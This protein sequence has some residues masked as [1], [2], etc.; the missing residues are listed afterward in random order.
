L[1]HACNLPEAEAQGKKMCGIAGF[2][3]SELS[4]QQASDSLQLMLKQLSRRGPDGHGTETRVVAPWTVSLGHRRLSIIDVEGGVQPMR[5][6][7]GD[8]FITFNGEI[9]N[10]QEIALELQKKGVCLRTRSDTEV[11]LESLATSDE[12]E[13]VLNALNGMFAFAFWDEKQQ[14]LLMARDRTG[15]KPL[16]YAQL[17]DGG[18][19]F[20]S[21][22]TAILELSAGFDRSIDP[23]SVSDFF[24]HDYVPPPETIIKG[25]KKLGFGEYL[26]WKPGKQIKI[27]TY[28]TPDQVPVDA[29][30]LKRTETDLA[31]DL[32]AR[33]QRAVRRQLISDVP[34]GVFLSGGIDSTLITALAAK[35]SS[36]RLSTFSIGFEEKSFDESEVARKIASQLGTEHHEQILSESV[37][38]GSLEEALSCLDEPLGDASILPTYL[39]AKL[40]RKTV[41]VCLGGDGGD[42]LWAGYSFYDAHR[43]G[44]LYAK[45]PPRFRNFVFK[46]FVNALPVK[47]TYQSTEWK[48]KR[49]VNRWD[50][51]RTQRHL[52]WLAG[53]DTADFAQFLNYPMIPSLFYKF[54]DGHGA[55]LDNL[56]RLDLTSYLPGSVLTKVDR[57]TMGNG[58]EARPPFLDN[59][60][61]DFSLGVPSSLKLR[62]HVT[63][64]LLKKSA[65]LIFSP[66]VSEAVLARPKKG[67]SVP[68]SRWIRGELKERFRDAI[69]G[70]DLYQT[71]LL[72]QGGLRHIFEEHCALKRDWGKTLWSFYVFD[73][74][75]KRNS[76]LL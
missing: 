70:S 1:G 53:T 42:E 19:A 52:R 16:Y 72:N 36:R 60:V 18:I 65:S 22:L 58:V 75:Y 40:A 28:W 56:L 61:V 49:F 66:A 6:A 51:S 74:W 55:D 50:P 30:A 31:Q 57:A 63:K 13:S 45:A 29:S 23:Q 76:R 35:E 20:A 71:G 62:S 73:Q 37:L 8:S 5:S 33:M 25:I 9:F 59:E 10:F 17:K 69:E 48:A 46:P 4:P 68:L 26:I 34:V 39:V 3:S 47:D 15:I 54:H 24:F 7:Q 2:I 38:L 21:E 12:Y 67:F 11:L 44:D 32:L 64:Y 27:K 43:W 41:K 14:T